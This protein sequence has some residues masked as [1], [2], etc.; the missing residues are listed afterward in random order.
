MANP[1]IEETK[2]T[3]VYPALHAER[4]QNANCKCSTALQAFRA[5]CGVDGAGG[6]KV[7]GGLHGWLALESLSSGHD[8]FESGLPRVCGSM[9]A[10]HLRPKI[11]SILHTPFCLGL[12]PTLPTPVLCGVGA[13]SCPPAV[14]CSSSLSYSPLPCV[15]SVGFCR[16]FLGADTFLSCWRSSVTPSTSRELLFRFVDAFAGG[17]P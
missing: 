11:P 10:P 15:S 7:A 17:W 6:G 1:E 16:F 3:N 4:N 13:L 2:Q 8:D 9:R 5:R 14:S 12:P